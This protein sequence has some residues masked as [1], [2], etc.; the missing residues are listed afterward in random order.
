MNSYY[1]WTIGCQMNT[2]DSDRL[3]AALEELGV[4]QVEKAGDADV[5]VLNS[6][7]V[8]QGAE[9]KVVSNLAW[10]APLKKEQPERIVALMG[11][12]VGPK[13]D[14]LAKR[15]PYVDVF[16]RPQ[17]FEPLLEMVGE[18]LGVDW[19]GC[20]GP[21]APNRP[22]ISC[23][24]PIIHGCDLMC[25]FC[26]IPYRRGRQVSRPVEEVALEVETLAAR[27]VKE[28]TLLGQTVDAYGY[29][30]PG[31]PNLV[32]LFTRLDRVEGIERIRFLTSHP[33]FMTQDIIQAVADVPKVC[34]HINLPVQAGDDGILDEMRRQYSR[35]DYIKLV[36]R[37]RETMPDV[38][39]NTDIIVG[40]PGE[41]EE[42]FQ[43]TMD[44]LAELRLDKVHCAAYSTRP[45]TIAFR[46][47]DDAVPEDEK[48]TRRQ[49][50]DQ[51]QEE[52][53]TEINGK[54]V[55][56]YVEVLVEGRRKGKWQGRT[57]SHKLVF[58]EDE[59]N[60]LGSLVQVKI[61]RSSPWSLSGTL[62]VEAKLLNP[63]SP[64][65]NRGED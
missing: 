17:Q 39:L 35:A 47:M 52:I 10:M 65:I 40:F 33:K 11:C 55:G 42:R 45:G 53:Q 24:V 64:E 34:E 9:D 4:Q 50:I 58:F 63:V 22:D 36:G 18:R 28:V 12:M 25:T 1:L 32:D 6:C 20:I 44:L 56:T 61:E 7:V 21:L 26:I 31:Q 57:R 13:S 16:M 51:Q 59:A 46:T 8:R 54:L 3:G 14:E 41:T 49:R 62:A 23:H 5:I 60:H 19:E 15:F 43:Q 37:I 2:A 29:D 38:A 27:G 48:T 30:L